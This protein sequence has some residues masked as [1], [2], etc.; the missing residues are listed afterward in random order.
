M[1]GTPSCSR[2]FP[3]TQLKGLFQLLFRSEN[4]II[5]KCCPHLPTNTHYQMNFPFLTQSCSRQHCH[6]NPA[7]PSLLDL[8]LRE[9]SI[10][11][12]TNG[13]ISNVSFQSMYEEQKCQMLLVSRRFKS[14]HEVTS[15]IFFFIHESSKELPENKQD[16]H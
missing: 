3:L 16:M 2:Y 5:E 8:S 11:Y 1:S 10:S 15:F 4:K 12:P 7:A 9:D 13:R 14:L 6:H